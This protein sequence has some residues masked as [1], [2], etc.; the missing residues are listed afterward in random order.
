L[1]GEAASVDIA[2]T[3]NLQRLVEI[4][5]ELLKK[6]VSRVNL[7]TGKFEEIKDGGTT[8]EEALASFAELLVEERK[9]RQ[10]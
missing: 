3:E 8:N 1:T 6:P 4:A 5:K 2:T 7:D 9:L 10:N